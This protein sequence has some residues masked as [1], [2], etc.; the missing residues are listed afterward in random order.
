MRKFCY[1]SGFE[2]SFR[3]H[4]VKKSEEENLIF[5]SDCGN[6][7]M[8]WMEAFRKNY[9]R[10][11]WGEIFVQTNFKSL[12]LFISNLTLIYLPFLFI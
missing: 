6:M 1:K 9:L 3:V 5:S 7:K 10:E 11:V 8:E 2:N 12:K 4:D